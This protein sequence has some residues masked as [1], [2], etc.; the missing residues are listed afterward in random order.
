MLK[1][2]RYKGSFDLNCLWFSLGKLVFP[3]LEPILQCWENRNRDIRKYFYQGLACLGKRKAAISLL[4]LN[5]VLSLRP[6]HFS[7]LV[8]RGRLYLKE[9]KPNLAARDFIKAGQVS[10]YRFT[11]YNLYSEYLRLVNKNE[12]E[13]GVPIGSDFT[14]VLKSI[15]RKDGG[16]RELK[17]TDPVASFREHSKA[18]QRYEKNKD[19]VP[20]FKR[21][22]FKELDREKFN[23]LGPITQAEIEAADWDQLMQ[24]LSS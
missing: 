6:N 2:G 10:S 12:Y 16:S 18:D 5:M 15:S 9:G 4:N 7:A 19:R 17:S 21:L 13:L 8:S 11:H 14:K 20:S 23:E 24:D 1:T 3:M 22:T